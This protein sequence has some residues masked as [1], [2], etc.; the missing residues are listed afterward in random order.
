M[1][2]AV[3]YLRSLISASLLA[4]LI[5]IGIYVTF[6]LALKGSMPTS[7]EI[8]ENLTRLYERFGYEII[9]IGAF[10]E[11]LVMVNLF[12]PGASAVT[13]GAI[14]ARSG[15]TDLTLAVLAASFGAILGYLVDFYLGKFGFGLVFR[16]F[17]SGEAVNK[18]KNRV[19]KS[20]TKTFAFSFIHPNIGSIVALA[21]GAVSMKFKNFLVLSS[22]S[23]FAWFSFWGVV[24]FALGDVFLVVLTKYIW[25]VVLMFLSIWLLVSLCGNAKR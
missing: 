13:L 7:A 22:L 19:E 3:R 8:V 2:P 25:I 14:F 9:I 6:L 10:L 4:P 23:T 24:V 18:A 11:S 17:G 21:A 12:V 16:V 1:K 15:Q 5:F 20:A